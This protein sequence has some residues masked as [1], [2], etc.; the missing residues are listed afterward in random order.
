LRSVDLATL[1]FPEPN[2]ELTIASSFGH[3]SFLSEVAYL[4]VPDYWDPLVQVS[5]DCLNYRYTSTN[6]VNSRRQTFH[7]VLSPTPTNVTAE[8]FYPD[9]TN[10]F[11]HIRKVT[12]F[13]SKGAEPVR[14][15]C[16]GSAGGSVFE[17]LYRIELLGTPKLSSPPQTVFSIS[18][19]F[20]SGARAHQ[21]YVNGQESY[22]ELPDTPKTDITI[23]GTKTNLGMFRGFLLGTI[24]LLGILGGVIFWRSR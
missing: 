19:Y 1:S 12:E 5:G 21:S 20:L 15:V 11:R 17:E 14:L 7:C 16:L 3:N 24:A 8:I 2:P 22:T 6:A 13:D 9:R 18:N 4:G 10:E 23:Y